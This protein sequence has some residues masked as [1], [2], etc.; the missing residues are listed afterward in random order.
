MFKKTSPKKRSLS[1]GSKVAFIFPGQGTQW[2]GMG[3]DLYQT[4]PSARQVFDEADESLGFDLS[5]LCFEGPE[6]KLRQTVYAQPAILTMSLACLE[7]A[8]EMGLEPCMGKPAYVAGHSL[9]EYTSLVAAGVLDLPEAVSLVRQ[10]GKLMQKASQQERGGMLAIL[11]LDLETVAEVCEW[12]GTEIANVNCP[13]QVVIA[14]TA[15]SLAEA[16]ELAQERG[17]RRVVTL[18]VCGPFHSSVMRRALRALGRAISSLRFHHPKVPIVANASARPL[19]SS[20]AVKK[21]LCIQLCYPVRW[22]ESVNLMVDRGVDTFVELG[23]GKVLSGMIERTA[24]QV[25]TINIGDLPSLE[26][27]RKIAPPG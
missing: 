24:P 1:T 20:Q 18:D 13:G 21:E 14:G 4:F 2:V 8:R 22:Q 6:E 16:R 27:A 5:R 7:A 17:A 11:G 3:K 15:E 19:T 10:R 12:S 26:R 25:Q 23:P 9:G